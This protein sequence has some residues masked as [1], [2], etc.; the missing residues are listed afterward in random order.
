[1]K[2]IFSKIYAVLE[3]SRNP[4]KIGSSIGTIDS[5]GKVIPK[6]LLANTKEHSRID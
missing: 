4:E 5:T 2:S 3:S 6:K 1:M